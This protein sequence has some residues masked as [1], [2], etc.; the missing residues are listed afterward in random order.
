MEV[1]RAIRAVLMGYVEI[2]LMLPFL[3]F[4]HLYVIQTDVFWVWLAFL[5]IFYG[6]GYAV[7]SLWRP[8]LA[9]LMHP[10]SAAIGLVYS[11]LMF[12]VSFSGF[13]SFLV[14]WLVIYRGGLYSVLP[15]H[16][17]LPLNYY[18]FSLTIY[19]FALILGRLDFGRLSVEITALNWGCVATVAIMLFM[20]NRYVLLQESSYGDQGRKMGRA[21]RWKNMMMIGISAA[22]IFIVAGIKPLLQAVTNM[23]QSFYIWIWD[24]FRSDGNRVRV[25]ERSPDIPMTEQISRYQDSDGDLLMRI[26]MAIGMIIVAIVLI[27][28]AREVIRVLI[29]RLQRL[30]YLARLWFFRYGEEPAGEQT[31][32]DEVE[33]LA[34]WRDLLDRFGH[35][36]RSRIVRDADGW[37]KQRD[38]AERVRYLYRS[39]VTGLIRDGYA[40]KPSHTPRETK[41]EADKWRARETLPETLVLMYEQV[42][43]GGRQP[44]DEQVI[45]MK[46]RLME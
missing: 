32:V 40:Y 10:L 3:L 6:I 14:A 15:I 5:G 20:M 4:V 9:G 18:V 38:N 36:V 19:L 33:R 31:Y 26:A 7:W 16:H 34:N 35:A 2:L 41:R 17:V 11:W 21:V 1:R 37:D 29:V 44:G 30:T 25:R 24:L 46:R 39:A 13:V 42:R 45:S 28:I 23:L 8:S 43:Y 12:D 22:F 27:Y